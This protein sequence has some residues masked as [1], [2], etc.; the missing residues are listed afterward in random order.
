MT[1][2]NR[3]PTELRKMFGANLRQLARKYPSVSALCRELGINRTQFNRYLLAESF[4]RPDV[5]DRICRFFEVDARILLK[6]LD[7]IEPPAD[8]PASEIIDRFLATGVEKTLATGFYHAAETSSSGQEPIRH[9]LLFVRRIRHCTLLRS[10][11]P[12]SQMPGISAPAREV[13][14][15]V[16]H[17]SGQICALMSRP[18]AQ[19]CRMMILTDSPEQAGTTWS[20]YVYRLAGGN[21]SASGVKRLE[22]HHLGHDLSLALQLKRR[23]RRVPYEIADTGVL[24]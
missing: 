24:T 17:V 9:G 5:L 19:D 18:G 20:G 4:P 3:S 13:Q 11:E 22:L 2:I 6:P 14:G 8:H 12:R 10:Y 16:S 23:A 7:E 21:A 1:D 15:I